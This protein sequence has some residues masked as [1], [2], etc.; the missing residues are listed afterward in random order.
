VLEAMTY[1]HR[2]HSVA[3]AGLAYRTKE[4]ILER[5]A[6]DPILRVRDALLEEGT[7]P[8]RLEELDRDAD[9]VVADAVAFALEDPEPPAGDLAAGMY[10][11]GSAAQFERMRPGSPA[12][13]DELVF[14]AGLGR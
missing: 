1:R 8:E 10:A 7:T 3:D 4:E 11:P 2:G 13:E 6:H 9:D 5:Q 14:Q 12:G